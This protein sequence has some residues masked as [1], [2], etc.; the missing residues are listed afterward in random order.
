[1]NA[2]D[3]PEPEALQGLSD[4]DLHALATEIQE[5]AA[6]L[7]ESASDSDEI[8]G[9]LEALAGNFQLVQ[10]E[11]TSREEQ[12]QA[13][14]ERVQNALSRIGA[15]SEPDADGG[16]TF[17]GEAAGV[18]PD[19]ITTGDAAPAA[20]A[21]S[22]SETLGEGSGTIPQDPATSRVPSGP[23]A[24]EGTEHQEAA[25]GGEDQT[26][27]PVGAV[28]GAVAALS[29]TRDAQPVSTTATAVALAERERPAHRGGVRR[30]ARR[31]VTSFVDLGLVDSNGKG[32]DID[33]GRLAALICKKHGQLSRMSSNVTYE[34]ITLASAKVM[35]H[36]YELG[37]GH[38]ENFSII[39]AA[40]QRGAALV[41]AGG[42]CAP[43]APNWDVFNVAEAMSPVEGFL[44]SVGA[45][46]GGIRYVQPPSW[47]E[48][49]PGVR[50]TTTEQDADGYTNQPDYGGPG[51]PGT[52]APK[53]CV[54]MECLPIVECEVDAVSQCVTFG[55]LQYRTFPEQVEAFLSH[56]AV[57]F[58][59]AK[60]ISYLNAIEA[61][62]TAV[63]A[64]PPYGATRGSVFAW[65]L[66]AHAYRKRNRM[67][68]DAPLDVL[69]PDSM[70]P[71]LKTDMINDLHLGLS[72][73]DVDEMTVARE[74]F[75]RLN[76]NVEF[77]YDFSTNY[78]S[79]AAMLQ[80]QVAGPLN[81]FP[82]IYRSYMFAPGTWIRLDGGTLDVGI[83]RDST[84]NSQNDLQIFAEEFTQVC[85][86]GIESI[87]LDLTLC[88]SGVG[89]NPVT[90]LSCDS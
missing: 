11:L 6:D 27:V 37:S 17:D 1:M 12:A 49:Q 76:L 47:P 70:I 48:A 45:P 71:L 34:P 88:P 33:R 38:E 29:A 56:L 77:Y 66:A 10:E 36:E 53:P 59:Q 20:A 83:V 30:G 46:R 52:T 23:N 9:Q 50:F 65:C 41:A 73:L 54:R 69:A 40:T 26:I 64:T 13:R 72:F 42:N 51:I 74:L 86:V 82:S 78:T 43:L 22:E 85:K 44:P 80:P 21:T 18:N 62:S 25:V 79:I 19:A 58:A 31:D 63:N 68:L 67:P 8:L 89:P 16:E 7:R 15:P 28:E 14:G 24:P 61:G 32:D 75:D 87:R 3:V 90:A 5:E 4:D 39:E 57:A 84:L 55:N 81:A 35:E 2:S 60:E